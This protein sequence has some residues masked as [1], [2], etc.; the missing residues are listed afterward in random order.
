[1]NIEVKRMQFECK[2]H[3]ESTVMKKRVN[4]DRLSGIVGDSCGI[5]LTKLGRQYQA[6]EI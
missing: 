4:K 6:R 2:N 3:N 5:V 1:M